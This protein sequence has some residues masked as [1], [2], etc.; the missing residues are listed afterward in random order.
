[1][2]PSARALV[3]D[4][5]QK[6]LE[7]A[8]GGDAK[9]AEA[10]AYLAIEKRRSASQRHLA[11]ALGNDRRKMDRFFESLNWRAISKRRYGGRMASRRTGTSSRDSAPR[12]A[13]RSNS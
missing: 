3:A 11:A 10:V 9:L 5:R 12:C 13:P 7:R 6:V 8:G 1:M 2:T 4:A